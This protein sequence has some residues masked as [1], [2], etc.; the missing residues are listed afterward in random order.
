MEKTCA[1]C[2]DSFKFEH[3]NDIYCSDDC[4]DQARKKRQK[5]KRD[6]IR[7]F[8]PLLVRNHEILDDLIKDG[9]SEI[10]NAEIEAYGLDISLCR[11]LNPPIEHHGKV[12]LDFG[13]Y[14]LITETDFQ[15]FKI[16]KHETETETE[17]PM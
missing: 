15:I 8:I 14:Y 9:K 12:M 6:P 2:D 11:H 5:Q 1:W 17:K 7:H 13:T 3:G 16:H 4:E 10:T